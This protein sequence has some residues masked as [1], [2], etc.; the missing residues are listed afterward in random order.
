MATERLRC[1]GFS[2]TVAAPTATEELASSPNSWTSGKP[3]RKSASLR[4]IGYHGAT[5]GFKA[6]PFKNKC[7]DMPRLYVITATAEPTAVI[8]RRGP[9]RWYHVIQWDM[10]RDEF[11]HGAWVKGRIYEENHCASDGASPF[12]ELGKNS[13]TVLSA[14]PKGLR[15]PFPRYRM[16]GLKQLSTPSI[17]CSAHKRLIS[18]NCGRKLACVIGCVGAVYSF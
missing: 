3:L 15:S 11:V 10:H 13:R 1:P 17:D 7:N 14:F 2:V 16:I 8:L 5:S 9:S 12:R 4:V 6:D 18:F